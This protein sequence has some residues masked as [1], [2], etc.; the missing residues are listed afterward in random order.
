[1]F[2][3]WVPRLST[4]TRPSPACQVRPVRYT[5]TTAEASRRSLKSAQ[6]RR[7]SSWRKYIF[8]TVSGVPVICLAWLYLE[9]QQHG[10]S[11]HNYELIAKDYVSPTASIFRLKAQ[12]SSQEAEKYDEVWKQ[13]IWNVQFKQPQLQIVRA[14]TPLPFT[15][16]SRE[17]PPEGTTFRF[18]IRND[19]QGEVSGYLHRLP[20]GSTIEV[21]GPNLEHPIGR[22][23]NEVVFFAGGT[24]IAPA[25]Q[26]AH[27]MF[28]HLDE[29]QRQEKK[30][31]IL[32][33]NRKRE[34]CLGGTPVND[35]PSTP[36]QSWSWT[37]LF[38]RSTATAPAQ[39]SS[40]STVTQA[41]KDQNLIV[42]DLN[43]LQ[44]RYPDSVSV[45][46]FVDEENTRIDST[47]V[48]NALSAFV[49][50]SNPN[51]AALKSGGNKEIII[52]GPPGFIAYLVGPKVWQN[53]KEEQGPLRG[54]L[55]PALT[56][57]QDLANVKVWKV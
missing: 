53:G 18:L 11:F 5:S 23:V 24:G 15:A 6:A 1:M 34:D 50:T 22:S 46:Y 39:Q 36:A 19:P 42:R 8:I 45:T 37:N 35:H 52:S 21:R 20:L 38:S 14:Y 55:G 27:A 26:V 17:Q 43:A 31:H 13:G 57:H 51:Q 49:Q 44:A 56:K 10:D 33:A 32:W 16:G 29:I 54:L 47:A 28:D 40:A 12:S 41:Q 4:C 9:P 3:R 25:L 7:P 2:R 30:L 48:S